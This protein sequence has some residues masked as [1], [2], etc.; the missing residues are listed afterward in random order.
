MFK[1]E[2]NARVKTSSQSGWGRK[3]WGGGGGKRVPHLRH[4]RGENSPHL[5]ELPGPADR[6]TCLGEVPHLSC[7]HNQE[8]KRNCMERLVIPRRRGTSPSRVP[9]PPFELA[10]RKEVLGF[11]IGPVLFSKKPFMSQKN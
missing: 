7:E 9:P 5:S 2:I 10:R 6:A 11:P 4:S 1:P 3:G 8:K